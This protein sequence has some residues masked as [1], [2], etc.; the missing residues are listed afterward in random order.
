VA[1]TASEAITDSEIQELLSLGCVPSAIEPCHD[2][3][4][5][6][7]VRWKD[8][9]ET[10]ASLLTD[11]PA[12]EWRL[13]DAARDS[14][15]PHQPVDTKAAIPAVPLPAHLVSISFEKVN[16]DVDVAELAAPQVTI[17]AGKA[18]CYTQAGNCTAA[19]DP[20]L[21]ATLHT[22]FTTAATCEPTTAAFMSA[23]VSLTQDH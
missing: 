13:L 1:W 7:N 17:D 8:S 21:L 4:A 3:T 14:T 16:P 22:D 11:G 2:A 15:M 12:Q 5:R 20:S 6:F 23:V 18:W 9:T 10:A 19:L